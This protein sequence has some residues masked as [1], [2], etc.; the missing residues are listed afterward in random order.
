MKGWITTV[1][2]VTF[3]SGASTGYLAGTS[4]TP[5]AQPTPADQYVEQARQTGV[6]KQADLDEIR[7]IYQEWEERVRAQKDQVGSLLRDQLNA[8]DK[9]Y[10]QRVQRIIDSYEQR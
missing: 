5:K 10:S 6:V 8:L 2:A 4:A 1:L 7:A 3:L 9:E